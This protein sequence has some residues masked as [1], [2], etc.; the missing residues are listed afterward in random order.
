MERRPESRVLADIPVRIWGMDASGKPFFENVLAGSLSSEGAQL[1]HVHH[2]LKVGEV[3]GIQYGEKKARFEVIWS[4]QAATVG[5]NEVGVRI[6]CDQSALWGEIATGDQATETKESEGRDRR[7]FVRHK[8]RFPMTLSF[9]NSSQAHMLCQA[10]DVSGHGC[11]IETLVP[12]HI[13][14]EFEISLWM[15]SE[16]IRT[17]AI[18]RARHLGVGMGIEFMSLDEAT[19]QRLQE[20]FAKLAES[21]LARAASEHY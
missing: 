21:T 16:K 6:L 19:E 11:Y 1:G 14:S 8:I 20:F 15:E 9:P 7:K 13:G 12:L 3:I 10:T 4:K 2:S 17:K 18:V 5:G